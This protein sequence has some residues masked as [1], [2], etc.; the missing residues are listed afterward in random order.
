MFVL[1][2]REEGVGFAGGFFAEEAEADYA[3]V[4]LG[5]IGGSDGCLETRKVFH[6]DLG[7]GE[8][9]VGDLAVVE[10]TALD[11]GGDGRFT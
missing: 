2:E 10:F 4:A 6:L 5:R 7:G 9:E 3:P 11:I 8:G 1:E